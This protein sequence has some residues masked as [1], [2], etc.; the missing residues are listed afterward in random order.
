MKRPLI[1]VTNDDS[2]HSK[3]IKT[4]VEIVKPFGDVVVVSSEVPMS[5]KSSAITVSDPLR[6]RAELQNADSVKVFATTGTPVDSVKMAFG[7]LLERIPDLVVS[8]INHGSNASVNVIYSGTL[9]AV[10]EACMH[11]VPAIGFS[12]LDHA[13]DADF[14]PSIPYIKTIIED[15]LANGLP[16]GVCLNVNI[17]NVSAE[18]IKGVK[19][20]TQA[21]AYWTDSFAERFD[22]HGFPYYWL[23]GTCVCKNKT[24][25]TDLWALENNYI[26]VVPTQV[27]MTAHTMIQKLEERYASIEKK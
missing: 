4:L 7:N 11:G 24:P 18:E 23:T 21:D 20:C 12:L 17:P 14:T 25:E 10:L 27:D 15:V 19:V 26:S 16:D 9:G 3:G 1:L 22:P 8:G 13:V 5:G 6:I 2:V